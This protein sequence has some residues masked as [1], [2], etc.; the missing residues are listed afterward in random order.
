MKSK[1][2]FI[3]FFI[4]FLTF[5]SNAEDKKLSNIFVT[6]NDFLLLKFDLFYSK[7]KHRI[8]NNLGFMIKYQYLG[9]R[10]N[11]NENDEILIEMIGI[12]DKNK[13]KKKRYYPKNKDCNILRNKLFLNQQ[14]Y[15]FWKQERNYSVS[16]E[17][18]KEVL[19]KEIFTLNNLRESK[20]DKIIDKTFIEI[21]II[22]PKAE[23]NIICKGNFAQVILD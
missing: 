4:F 21:E 8:L 18:L 20:I 17:S 23:K 15:S 12:M 22:H 19:K 13:Y 2:F 3:S 9:F 1:F 10:V 14:G 6:A 7:N 16:E 11:I 5:N